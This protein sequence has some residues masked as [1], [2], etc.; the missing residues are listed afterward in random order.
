MVVEGAGWLLMMLSKVGGDGDSS[1][2]DWWG[3]FRFLF[4]Y[5]KKL[6]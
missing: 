6:K 3:W 1:G 5:F 4:I 2:D